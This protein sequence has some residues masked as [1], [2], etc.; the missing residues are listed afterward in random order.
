MILNRQSAGLYLVLYNPKNLNKKADQASNL[1]LSL[2]CENE[3]P[4]FNR[5]LA[6]Y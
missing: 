2:I 3:E 4:A 5:V 6:F 1:D